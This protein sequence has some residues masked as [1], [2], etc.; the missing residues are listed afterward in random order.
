MSLKLVLNL[1]PIDLV[2]PEP[3]PIWLLP[4]EVMFMRSGLFFLCPPL[5]LDK[6]PLYCMVTPY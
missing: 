5:K 6:L 1:P 4:R 3:N 2:S